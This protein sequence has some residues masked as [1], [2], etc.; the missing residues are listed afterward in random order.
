MP[1][2]AKV[3]AYSSHEAGLH[4]HPAATTCLMGG[5]RSVHRADDLRE[6]LALGHAGTAEEAA[7]AI[8][9]R[10]SEAAS[11][12]TGQAMVIEG[13]YVTQ[14]TST[15]GDTNRLP[16]SPAFSSLCSDRS[17]LRVLPA[18]LLPPAILKGHGFDGESSNRAEFAYWVADGNEGKGRDIVWHTEES[19]HFLLKR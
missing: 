17:V 16:V 4:G 8:Y 12:V 15:N 6:L 7:A 11:F 19:V 1:I 5:T 18:Q 13:G 14:E 9:W 3:H 10:C 2:P